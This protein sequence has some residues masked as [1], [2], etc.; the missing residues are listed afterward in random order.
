MGRLWNNSGKSAWGTRRDFYR[1]F[2]ESCLN[3]S[4]PYKTGGKWTMPG[5]KG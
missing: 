4:L 3:L 1:H 5:L 2:G